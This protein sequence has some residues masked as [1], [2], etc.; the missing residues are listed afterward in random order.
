M[1]GLVP[2]IAMRIAR[3]DPT[4]MQLAASPGKI[5]RIFTGMQ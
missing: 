2:A 4:S 3:L 1:A 5:L